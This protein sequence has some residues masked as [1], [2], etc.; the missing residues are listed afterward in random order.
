MAAIQART[1]SAASWPI[2]ARGTSR[3]RR[4]AAPAWDTSGREHLFRRHGR[5]GRNIGIRHGADDQQQ[6][7]LSGQWGNVAV[8]G[9][10]RDGER[11]HG[12]DGHRGQR[13]NVGVGRQAWL[14]WPPARNRVNI[15]NSSTTPAGL[16]VSGTNQQVGNI[17]GSGTTQVNAGSSLTANDIVQGAGDRRHVNKPRPGDD[18]RQQCLGQPARQ[19][20][21]PD[22]RRL[23]KLRWVLSLSGPT[24]QVRSAM[25]PSRLA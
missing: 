12:S 22:R 7:N 6:H 3:Y 18:R 13:R 4:V 23:P 24:P 21:R 25:F 1:R 20:R 2:T 10:Y 14:P 15:T 5:L 8:Q 11:W 19:P 16:L 17:S 9:R